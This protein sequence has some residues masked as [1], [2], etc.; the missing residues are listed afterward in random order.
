MH[1]IYSPK[2]EVDIGAHIFPTLK[3]RLIKERLVKEGIAA[4]QDFI[5]PQKVTDEEVGLVHTAAYIE[6][7][8]TGTLTYVE[9]LKLELPYSKDLVDASY[10]CAGG[11][12]LAARLAL[13]EKIAVHLGGGFH[14]AY[15]D[16]GE[17]FCVFND[18]AIAIKVLQSGHLIKKAVV[19][20]VD[21]HQGNGTAKI[22]QGDKNVFT[23][24][25][26]QENLYP[27]PKEKSNWDI[28]LEDGCGDKKYLEFL[29]EAIE[30]IIREFKP[31]FAVYLAGA[32]PY[33]DD[34][35]GSLDISLAGLKERDEFT[36]RSLYK[37][38]VPVAIVLG[39]GYA[40]D[41]EDTV[42]IHAN[43][44]KSALNFAINE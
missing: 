43:T 38:N 3:C 42:T 37:N 20:D 28:G 33:Q 12:I 29:K 13:K 8:K 35:L 27:Y 16:H 26:H 14:H 10:L 40:C 6:K 1:I 21:L 7:L 34:Q 15:A 11:T 30:R 36:L 4:K 32:D 17:G 9:M 25:I 39:G 41:I 44:V 5:H 2:Y 23:F 22:F 19:I 31:D 24:S 18:V